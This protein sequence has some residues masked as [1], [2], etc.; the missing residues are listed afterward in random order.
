MGRL[1][2]LVCLVLIMAGVHPAP[3][4]SASPPA[5][6]TS[7]LNTSFEAQEA[8]KKAARLTG[9]GAWAAAAAALQAASDKFAGCVVERG[10]GCFESVA[11]HVARTISSWP[12]EGLAAYREA[13]EPLARAAAHRAQAGSGI[14]PLL[15]AADRYFPT[16]AAAAALDEAAERAIEDGRFIA[17]RRWYERLAATHP[18][19]KRL[20]AA[21]SAKAALCA[22]WSG[23]RE[24]LERAIL[25]FEKTP[26]V[27]EVA[28]TGR[29]APITQFLKEEL[30]QGSGLLKASA[31]RPDTGVLA[32]GNE[33]WA[34]FSVRPEVEARMWR[35]SLA[36]ENQIDV[37]PW[38][39][40]GPSRQDAW[41]RALQ[42][43]RLVAMCPVS[44]GR[45]VYLHNAR[46][47]WAVDSWRPER[48]SWKLELAPPAPLDAGA[49]MDEDP[50]PQ[51][52][53]LLSE[54]RLYLS[55]EPEAPSE[56]K[57]DL[58]GDSG[59]LCLDASSGR[60]LWKS[61]LRELAAEFSQ[62]VLDG[63]PLMH[64][65]RL[66]AIVRRRK[67]FG[68]ESCRVVRFDPP[69]A[70]LPEEGARAARALASRPAA[71]APQRE[72]LPGVA[73]RWAAH[74]G[75]A[76][77]GSYGYHRPTR[78]HMAAAGDLVFAESNLGTIAAI[79][80]HSGRVVWL[81][82][83]PSKFGDSPDAAWPARPR[84]PI[85]SW[86]YPA[87]I[88]WRDCVVCAPLDTDQ[89][90]VLR[91]F[92]GEEVARIPLESLGLPECLVGLVGDRLYLVGS[93]VVCYDLARREIVWQRLLE[94]PALHGRGAITDSG[95]WLPTETALLRYPL[96][97]GPASVH[98]WTV[99]EAGNLL[100]L[101]DQLVVASA[102]WLTG[103][104]SREAAFARMEHR[105]AESPEDPLAVLPL[106]EL[107]FEMGED[108]RGLQAAKE[109]LR[110][111]GGP[112][113]VAAAPAR[114]E[115]FDRLMRLADSVPSRRGGHD[116]GAG[117]RSDDRPEDRAKAAL[118]L[119]ELAGPCAPGAMARLTHRFRLARALAV[120]ARPEE[121]VAAYQ[122]ILED[123]GLRDL[124]LRPAPPL[125]PPGADRG[126][127]TSP[128]S[129]LSAG[130]LAAQWIER[131]IAESGAGAYARV[132]AR[133]ADRLRVA[134]EKQD[135]AALVDIARTY[136]NSRAAG[137]SLL[138]H[139][140][141]M[142]LAGRQ[143]A[144]IGS[145]RQALAHRDLPQRGAAACELVGLLRRDHRP[146]EALEWA[147][148]ARREDAGWTC[149][150]GETPATQAIDDAAP[151]TP[152]PAWPIHDSWRRLYPDR[153]V[154]L[155]PLA[156]AAA[157]AEPLLL[158]S[159]AALEARNPASGRALWPRPVAGAVQPQ[160]IGAHAGR[161]IFATAHRVFALTATSGMESWALGREPPEDPQEDPETIPAWTHHALDSGRLLCGSDRGEL[162]RLNCDDGAVVWRVMMNGQIQ[163]PLAQD[164]RFAAFLAWRGRR[165][166]IHVLDVQTGATIRQ[167]E[168]ET[169]WP[170]QA[171]RFTEA[172]ALVL[173][174]SNAVQAMN[175]QTGETLWQVGTADR[176][177]PSTLLLGSHGLYISPDGRRMAKLDPA[178]GRTLWMTSPIGAAGDEGLSVEL[179]R[180]LLIGAAG[181]SIRAF[182][183]LDGRLLWSVRGPA[184]VRS[185]PPLLVGDSLLV[186]HAEKE[187]QGGDKPGAAAGRRFT[188]RRY[189]LLDGREEPITKSGPWITEPL[190]AFGGL[191]VRGPALILLDG[192]RVIGYVRG[193]EEK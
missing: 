127:G 99:G 172:G 189:R 102:A 5:S 22:A 60:P 125:Q 190:E 111:A 42:S 16:S 15:E 80:V 126:D 83:Y 112:A 101:G 88:A 153:V 47:V 33:R 136:P 86:D 155:E 25:E 72:R 106:A 182:D 171:M 26:A 57:A 176:F 62:T 31:P 84:R 95:L 124:R 110:R 173:V 52:T 14:E 54:G 108:S 92:T 68:F 21:W 181:T 64:E 116:L 32:A 65:G 161:L 63:A 122:L 45:H 90:F 145:I 187:P 184:G 70:E 18:D 85:R 188:I 118:E 38:M 36:D 123:R 150:M 35:S 180:G 6:D 1:R 7:Y 154:V 59:L 17:A 157:D 97:G 144:A 164:S 162:L 91:Q 120:A 151:A 159:G 58:R 53:S 40:E 143:D 140:R 170:I 179:H 56:E 19:R 29:R 109:S 168:S 119:L 44:D 146:E 27:P 160:Y 28:W 11:D 113:G 74:I 117:G 9:D 2:R 41:L 139:A 138:L 130:V 121:A 166:T 3:L 186:I 87:V 77:T 61:D 23:Q 50:P 148:R 142:S 67:Q 134:G 4:R 158:C 183:S 178:S 81:R 49:L 75:E 20:G 191:Y 82:T 167:I 107:A 156:A 43:G 89:L 71:S 177:V 192:S 193:R 132:A 30:S 69:E 133:A 73:P 100:P 137:E 66:F 10:E 131:L 96:D 98:R 24:V 105:A 79:S 48:P 12:D 55:I 34:R 129:L 94:A 128:D 115:L 93:Q 135:A 39:I 78:S 169:D 152:G 163:E 104:S 46:A 175:P 147:D 174:L 8:L 51:F 149:D 114:Q 76:A 37:P 13:F 103:L 165:H 185:E 141:L